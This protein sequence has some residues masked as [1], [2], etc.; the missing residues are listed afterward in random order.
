MEVPNQIGSKLK[1]F[2]LKYWSN[3]IS[4]SWFFLLDLA[5]SDNFLV[6]MKLDNKCELASS[7]EVVCCL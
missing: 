1:T 3:M 2:Y 5:S 4:P 6:L 7:N